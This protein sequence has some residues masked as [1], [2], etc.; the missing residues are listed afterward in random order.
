VENLKKRGRN[1][2][3]EEKSEAYL[4]RGSKDWPTEVLLAR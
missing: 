1:K 2:K 3:I 4:S